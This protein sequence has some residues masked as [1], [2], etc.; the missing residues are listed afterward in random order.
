VRA[1]ESVIAI[2]VILTST[3]AWSIGPILAVSNS[4][5]KVTLTK[6]E[7]K[8]IYLGF[9]R[10]IDDW[11]ISPL[12]QKES[13]PIRDEFYQSV[14]G[15]DPLQMKIFQGEQ[16]FSGKARAHPVLADDPAVI[17]QVIS[18][19]NAIGYVNASTDT[20]KVNILLRIE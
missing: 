7:L 17:Q 12:D 20:S 19:P 3:S 6:E 9:Q 1:F 13:S 18:D 15:K 14:T 2:V 8:N 10:S 5:H 4:T 16:I 11:R